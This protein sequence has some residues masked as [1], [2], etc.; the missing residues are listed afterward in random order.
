[1]Q[2]K[3]AQKRTDKVAAVASAAP[4][5][6]ILSAQ[7]VNRQ[8]S[9]QNKPRDLKRDSATERKRRKPK[10]EPALTGN[11]RLRD[12][13]YTILNVVGHGGSSAVY[14]VLHQQSKQIQALK[15]VT[16]QSLSQ[17]MV[18]QYKREVTFLM[19]LNKKKCTYIPILYNY[20]HNRQ[21]G[22]ID[23]VSI[24]KKLSD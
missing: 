12:Q 16:T 1:M 8:S 21:T 5:K 13:L 20:E 9:L 19:G 4:Y 3:G 14:R 15:R 23:L 2:P 11:I 7:D 24:Q 10:D 22:N 6:S 17:E 18:K